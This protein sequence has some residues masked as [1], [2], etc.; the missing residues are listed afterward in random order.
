VTA[1]AW[2]AV[3]HDGR[4][5]QGSGR[6]RR[7]SIVVVPPNRRRVR[8]WYERLTLFRAVRTIFTIAAALVLA[9]GALARAIEPETFTSIGLAWW[10]AVT[11]VTTVGYGDVVPVSTGGRFVG[12]ALMLTGVSL[13]PLITSVVVSILA[14]KRAQDL[15][16]EEARHRHEQAARLARIEERLERLPGAPPS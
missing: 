2:R 8:A 14:A 5:S 6:G 9:G 13:I 7:T 3:V 10:W 16:D 15:S 1:I 12:G 11:T 4:R